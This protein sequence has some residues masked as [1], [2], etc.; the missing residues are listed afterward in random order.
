MEAAS[1]LVGL[2]VDVSSGH[3]QSAS[4]PVGQAEGEA[5]AEQQQQ[6]QQQVGQ[7][8]GTPNMLPLVQAI[9][10]LPHLVHLKLNGSGLTRRSLQPLTALEQLTSLTICGHHSTLRC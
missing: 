6:Q 8:D 9:A 7:G 5:G 10:G 2:H 4:H 3:G 1:H